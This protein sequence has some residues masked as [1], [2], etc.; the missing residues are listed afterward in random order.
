MRINLYIFN[1]TRRGGIYGVGTYIR[2]LIAAL[3]G[4]DTTICVVNITSDKPQIQTE[5]VEGVKYWYIPKLVQEQ[6]TTDDQKIT[7]MYYRNVVYLLQLHIE[8]KNN[9]LFHLNY[10]QCGE[11]ADE[12]KKAF[13]CRIVS[14]VHFTDWGFKIFDNLPRLRNIL[15]GEHPDSFGEEVKKS[16]EEDKSYYSKVDRIVCLSDYMREILCRDYG[17]DPTKIAVVP[18]GLSDVSNTL[19]DRKFLRKKWNIPRGEKIILFAGRIDEVKGISYLIRSF[20]EIVDK[21]PRFRLIIAGSGSYDTC[22][23]EAKSICTKI[24]FAG[25]LEKEELHELYSIADIGVVPSLFEPFGFV[26]VEMMMHGLPV[27]ATE[28]SGLNEVVDPTCGLKIPL[29]KQQD[30]VTIDPSFLAQKMVYLIQHPA[31]ARKMGRNGR[32]RYLKKYTTEAFRRNMI[33]LYSSL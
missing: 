8:D 11:L 14:V 29:E 18:N 17:L 27:I 28:T 15:H 22:L 32:N 7:A 3:R 6:R 2:E 1:E 24:T 4:S 10:N 33:D 19:V 20:R 26:A 12:L 30:S 9:L 5:E 16:V 25:L 31:E 21:F 23:Q 13:D